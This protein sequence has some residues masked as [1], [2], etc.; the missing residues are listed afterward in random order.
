MNGSQNKC[1]YTISHKQCEVT[2]IT[3]IY[4]KLT[5]IEFSEILLFVSIQDFE[6]KWRK[7][8]Q[9]KLKE[10]L[11]LKNLEFD[12]FEILLNVITSSRIRVEMSKNNMLKIT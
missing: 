8:R 10:F 4:F 2:N 12:S 7:K 3:M 11:P 9:K 5:E 1:N 6:E